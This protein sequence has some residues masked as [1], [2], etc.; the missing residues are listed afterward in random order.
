MNTGMP[1]KTR[2]IPPPVAVITVNWN[3]HDDTA[4]LLQSLREQHPPPIVFVVD[5]GSTDGSYEQLQASFPE[6]R[7][8][9]MGRNRGF[10]AANNA[11]L[12]VL[13]AEAIPFA[14][15]INNDTIPEPGALGVLV[16]HM[17]ERPAAGAAGCIV[18]EADGP[19]R[20]IQAWGGGHIIP[21]LGT[22]KLNQSE[23]EPLEFITGASL[24]LRTKALEDVGVF[25]E[26]F[27]LYWEDADLCFRLREAGW[28][29]TVAEAV[30]RHKGS[31]TTGRFPRMRAYHNARSFSLLMHKH[32]RRPR[33]CGF[34]AAVA[35]SFGKLLRGNLPAAAGRWQ[36]WRAGCDAVRS[37]DGIVPDGPP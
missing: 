28:K 9:Q 35:Q 6:V 20:R 27:F 31:A 22:A 2:A 21:W 13:Q 10:G 5:N 19:G 25:D 3:T 29:L 11:A 34:T 4:R 1:R 14:W 18:L 8:L 36:G 30:V 26:H 7:Y 12:R 15:L 16:D 37:S 23:A 33:L 24:F 17:L 32:A